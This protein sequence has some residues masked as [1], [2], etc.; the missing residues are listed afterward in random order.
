MTKC[1]L[2]VNKEINAEIET[3]KFTPDWSRWLE[4]RLKRA[5]GQPPWLP[6]YAPSNRPQYYSFI[7]LLIKI[8]KLKVY[9]ILMF[10]VFKIV[11]TRD[12]EVGTH[13]S[14]IK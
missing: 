7:L 3:V 9:L 11:F 8:Q 6:I 4:L 13:A 1:L 10:G 2:E 5:S 14:I 12:W